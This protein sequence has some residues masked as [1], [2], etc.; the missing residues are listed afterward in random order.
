MS[1]DNTLSDVVT[2]R[3]YFAVRVGGQL[4]QLLSY[5]V[6]RSDKP[7]LSESNNDPIQYGILFASNV[8]PSLSAD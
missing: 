1:L 6:D 7:H 4:S 2:S 3:S 8:D 5:S